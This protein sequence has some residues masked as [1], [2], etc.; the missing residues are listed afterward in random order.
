MLALESIPTLNATLN[1][2]AT[3]FLFSGYILIKQGNRR[4]HMYAM[5]AA[6]VMSAVF[7]GFYLY[8]HFNVGAVTRYERT[9]ILRAIYFTILF[10]HIPLAVIVVPGCLAAIWHAIRG[11]FARHVRVTR[12]LW[13]VW[14][15]VSITGVI[16]YLM[17]YVFH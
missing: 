7:L 8:Y 3:I 5:I 16:I 4:G 10:T 6:L 14:I 9:G 17:L 1:G 15:Y 11:N 13:P 2:I 12:W